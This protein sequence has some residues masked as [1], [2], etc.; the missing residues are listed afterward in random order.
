M[1]LPTPREEALGLTPWDV[2]S[3]VWVTCPAAL[4]VTSAVSGAHIRFSNV[5][6]SAEMVPSRRRQEL[7]VLSRQ[8]AVR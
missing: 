4:P 8:P 2:Y 5:V 7:I 3:L 1:L 6:P